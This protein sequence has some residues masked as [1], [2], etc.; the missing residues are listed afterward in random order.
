L[1][2]EFSCERVTFEQNGLATLLGLPGFLVRGQGRDFERAR[3]RISCFILGMSF[4]L[5][6]LAVRNL[7]VTVI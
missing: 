5:L 4:P 2:L 3:A 7:S 6:M 1:H